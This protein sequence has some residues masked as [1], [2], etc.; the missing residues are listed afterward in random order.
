MNENATTN[1]ATTQKQNKSLN[2]T[3]LLPI[4]SICSMVLGMVLQQKINSTQ[5]MP[6]IVVVGKNDLILS[7]ML[8]HQDWA[9]DPEAVKK[10]LVDPINDF[11]SNLTRQGYA[12]IEVTKDEQ[13]GYVVSALPKSYT[14]QSEQLKQ[15]VQSKFPNQE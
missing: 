13:G 12:V 5:P 7:S 10:Y 11:Q 14:D 3:Y 15:Y 8:D 1:D 4:V 6:P 9:N 2:Y